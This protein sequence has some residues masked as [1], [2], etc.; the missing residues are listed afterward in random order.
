MPNKRFQF[1][2][3]ARSD[4]ASIWS[5]TKAEWSRAQ[6]DTYTGILK[7]TVQQLVDQP[8]RGRFSPVA[9]AYRF[10]RCRR[11]VIYYRETDDGIVIVRIL[12]ER[13]LPELHL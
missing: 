4:L 13:M 7:T 5:Y 12:H 2:Q 8:E 11:H 6:A 1:T 10:V 9:P 3:K